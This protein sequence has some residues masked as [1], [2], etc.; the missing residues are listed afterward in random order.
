MIST[1]LPGDNLLWAG[2]SVLITNP[3]G[4]VSLGS[5]EVEASHQSCEII[6]IAAKTGRFSRLGICST[7]GPFETNKITLV[8]GV[9]SEPA[10]GF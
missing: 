5:S 9:I 1:L 8:P 4:I 2:G 10:T 7:A 6:F 3:A